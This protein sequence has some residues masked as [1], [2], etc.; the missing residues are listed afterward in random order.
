MV[1]FFYHLDALFGPTPD[2]NLFFALPDT[3]PV[4]LCSREKEEKEE[5]ERGGKKKKEKKGKKEE[6]EK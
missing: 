3:L 4:R 2:G 6:L 1:I 5:G